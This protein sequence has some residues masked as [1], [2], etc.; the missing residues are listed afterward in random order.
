MPL[1]RGDIRFDTYVQMI[2]SSMFNHIYRN[3]HYSLLL[4]PFESVMRFQGFDSMFNY[5]YDEML[6][7]TVVSDVL[8][9]TWCHRYSRELETFES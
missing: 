7:I 1:F 8:H 6:S 5:S 4:L 2:T 9:S 3:I